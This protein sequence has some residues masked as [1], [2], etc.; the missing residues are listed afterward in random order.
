MNCLLVEKKQCLISVRQIR[1]TQ[2]FLKRFKR[3]IFSKTQKP[4]WTPR[5]NLTR[6]LFLNHSWRSG[7]RKD[8]SWHH[9]WNPTSDYAT[10]TKTM[11]NRAGNAPFESISNCSGM[12]LPGLKIQRIQ[13]L[14]WSHSPGPT[15]SLAVD[16]RKFI[17]GT[18]TSRCWAWLPPGES[19]SSKTWWRISRT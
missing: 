15:L 14:P 3:A 18:V 7:R 11:L 4:L 16:F 10:L 9:F 8:S 2:S 19:N 13:I 1:F 5:R 12:R 6:P 17:I